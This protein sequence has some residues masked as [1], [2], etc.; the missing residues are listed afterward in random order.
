MDLEKDG[1]TNSKRDALVTILNLARDRETVG[2]L[3]E[4]G[5]I[6][7][8]IRVINVL[9]EEAV[10]ILEAVVKRGGLAAI[11]AAYNSIKKLGVI[12][13]E[14]SD[15]ARESAAASLVT[16][17]RKRGIGGCGGAGSGSINRKDY[18]GSDGDGNNE[19][20]TEGRGAV[21]DSSE[22]ECWV[23]YE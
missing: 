6:E 8:V 13:R 22:M 21:E 4:G 18:M 9:P 7:T 11:V 23:G 12:L 2:R 15:T 17:C 16:I 19:S 1:P 10:T 14:G 3:V 20:S 5:V